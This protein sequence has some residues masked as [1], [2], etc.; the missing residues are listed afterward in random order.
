MSGYC[1]A[2]LSEVKTPV[3]KSRIAWPSTSVPTAILLPSYDHWP[4]SELLTSRLKSVPSGS[5][6]KVCS[7]PVVKLSA[8]LIRIFPSVPRGL[9]D[10]G[11]ALIAAMAAIATRPINKVI[12]RRI[13]PLPVVR[14]PMPPPAGTPGLR[15]PRR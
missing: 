5:T 10:A 8:R 13:S 2:R 6:V 7:S 15:Y 11:L 14:E 4:A 9:A 3:S 12:S 1:V